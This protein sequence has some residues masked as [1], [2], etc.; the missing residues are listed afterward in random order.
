MPG[1]LVHAVTGPRSGPI[2]VV[3]DHV[4][5]RWDLA[6]ALHE[7]GIPAEQLGSAEQTRRRIAHGRFSGVV[8]AAGSEHVAD[9]IAA[10]LPIDADT[11]EV[12]FLLVATRATTPAAVVAR[13]QSLLAATQA[14]WSSDPR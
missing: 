4:G 14:S 3:G 5:S 12:P 13:V 7:A 1:V 10:D 8:V 2:L 11:G 6:W 9:A